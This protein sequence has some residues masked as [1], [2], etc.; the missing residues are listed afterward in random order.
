[1][2]KFLSL[3]MVLSVFA[4]LL[5]VPA[6]AAGESFTTALAVPET[7][8]P[9]ETVTVTVT[10]TNTSA[11]GGLLSFDGKLSY[12]SSVLT[13][14][15]VELGTETGSTWVKDANAV[16]G[17]VRLFAADDSCAAPVSAIT[18]KV[19]FTVSAD[20]ASGT[21]LSFGMTEAEGSSA[22]ADYITGT[23][24]TASSRV[25]V[26]PPVSDVK[27]VG[28]GGDYKNLSAAFA[29]AKAGDKLN[30]KL[31]SNVNETGRATVPAGAEIVLDLNGF[32]ATNTYTSGS[33][34]YLNVAGTL[35]IKGEGAVAS[36]NI[37]AKSN[38]IVVNVGATLNV[39]DSTI[40]VAGSNYAIYNYGGTV[41]ALTNATVRATEGTAVYSI[42]KIG[43]IVGGT[44]EGVRGIQICSATV[45]Q[46]NYHGTVDSITG[47][48]ITGT[49]IGIYMKNQSSIGIITEATVKS[50]G[51]A[52][53]ALYNSGEIATIS[54]S[55]IISEGGSY[56]IF[57]SGANAVITAINNTKITL[58]SATVGS[59]DAIFNVYGK[60]GTIDADT[61]ITANS[62]GI[63]NKSTIET[64]SATIN[65]TLGKGIHM[66]GAS[67]HINTLNA[68]ITSDRR[69][70][71]AMYSGASIDTITGTITVLGTDADKCSGIVMA[72]GS[73]VGTINATI[74]CHGVAINSN[75]STID[76]ISGGTYTSTGNAAVLNNKGA[77]ITSI[78]GGTFT[79]I[80]RG[81]SNYGTVSSISGGAFLATATPTNAN[82]AVYTAS[83]ATTTIAD[84][85]KLSKNASTGYFEVA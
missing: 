83:G 67:A 63:L 11:Q 15:S 60:I 69:V 21:A 9:G 16:N 33:R 3:L 35:T 56:G 12:P 17:V 62:F 6:Y 38:T 10:A 28:T 2:K 74:N 29:A 27:T 30:L 48:T 76:T 50:V 31:I 25:Y 13:Y 7:V 58:N 77:T 85:K 54:G 34:N 32:T 79:G 36:A 59:G 61:V 41:A 65:T 71:V 55:S 26:A 68:N 81:L 39:E 19:T 84:G 75:A 44:Y 47:A 18:L 49:G 45:S 53:T 82:R 42:S 80:A 46:K 4:A 20:A 73:H 8:A 37:K 57:N 66:T 52:S 64:V 40:T 24:S 23:S 43:T 70:A 14:S 72:T 5:V 22:N 78:T 1:M 51:A